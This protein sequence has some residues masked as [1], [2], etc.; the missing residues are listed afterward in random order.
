MCY[1]NYIC[2][3]L[4]YKRKS[5]INLTINQQI[6]FEKESTYP[7]G[8]NDRIY[9]TKRLDSEI[10]II[11]V[12]G[13][14]SKRAAARGRMFFPNEPEGAIICEYPPFCWTK[15]TSLAQGSAKGC[16]NLSESATS[17]CVRN[18][19]CQ[20]SESHDI[21]SLNCVIKTYTLR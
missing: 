11:S 10:S 21:M 8:P 9:L 20:L 2:E 3:V 15:W 1:V 12:I 18:S 14:T 19:I 13:E 7:K 4:N 16:E 5:T 17:T 6:T